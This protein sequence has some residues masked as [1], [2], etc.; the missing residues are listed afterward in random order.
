M[1]LSSSLASACLGAVTLSLIGCSKQQPTDVQQVAQLDQ[2]RLVNADREPQ[3]WPTT[4][5]DFG[6]SH[7]SPMNRINKNNIASLGFAWEYQ[8]HT[9]RGLEATPIV[10]D[11]VMY[12]SGVMGRAYALD[13]KSGKEIWTFDPKVDGQVSRKACC[14][15]VNRGVA[16][17]RGTVYVAALD[18][19]LFALDAA[20][21]AIQWQ[22]DTVIDH[23]RGY[24]S[25]G[26]PEIAG[27]VVVVGNAGGEYD[28][29]GYVSAY[30]LQSGKLAWRFFTVPGD[31]KKPFEHPELEVA[32]KTWDK[33]S[34][35]DLGL[36]APTWDGM[37]YD[38]TL[39]LIYIA[40]GNAAPW[41]ESKRSPEGGDNLFTCSIIALDADTG[42]MAWYYQEV[43]GDQ[44]DYDSNAPMILA[45]LKIDGHIRAVLM[46]APKNGFFYVFDRKNG[47][48][49]SAKNFVPVN[50]TTG[51]DPTTKRP[52]VDKQAVDYTS[53][54][55][56]IFPWGG[57]AHS[58]T[59]MAFS[60]QSG[61][62]YIPV[63]EG[64][65]ILFDPTDHH[66]RR[67]GL[68]NS[69]TNSI[70]LGAFRMPPTANLPLKIKS[71][72]ESPALTAA[73]ADKQIRAY[74]DAWDPV[75]Q[76]RVWRVENANLF[77]RSG[78][79]ATGGGIVVQ[80]NVGGELRFYDDASGVL[81]KVVDTGTSIIAAPMTYTI[82]DE[83]YIAVM[84]GIGGGPLSFAPPPGSAADKYGNQGRVLAFKLGGA[85]TPKPM[86]L[87]TP[88]A[89]PEPP[90][91]TATAET[92]N[93]GAA[94][95]ALNCGRCHLNSS[96][97]GATPDLR[98][99]TIGT[100]TAF[101]KIVLQGALR[102]LGMPQWDDVLSEQESDA[103]H[104]YLIS[105]A[106]EAFTTPQDNRLPTN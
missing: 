58:W 31:P 6:K 27:K 10:I 99:M 72:L 17:W 45:D 100:H 63:S 35:W 93:K 50:W 66:E 55:K 77:D 51:I 83:Q 79:L 71:A 14:D 59:P 81:L 103:I 23:T 90:K 65:N 62:V 97:H 96:P 68:A 30:N 94:L 15:N 70:A 41:S 34:R 47:E 91:Q 16:V 56:V 89:F 85:V 98:R 20:T 22:T 61:L 54:P 26:A 4:G 60:L 29:R 13:A 64:A 1:N 53:G 38:P 33:N 101:N 44:W 25:T 95:F 75:N 74:L 19:R 86:L 12:T 28:A 8:T 88:P 73:V 105:L 76:K 78:V 57:G 84:A 87:P 67:A 40:T 80:G 82:G 43:P 46:H 7:Y 36:G 37:V 3:N 102:P 39:N 48:V 24:T 11:G 104:A 5:R 92:I 69:V 18:G 52:L 49:L 42:R 32:A 21:G 9:N 106:W 2:V